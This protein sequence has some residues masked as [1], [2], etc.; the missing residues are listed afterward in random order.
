[1]NKILIA[2]LFTL[3]VGGLFA[4]DYVDDINK[5]VEMRSDGHR[6]VYEMNVGSFTTEGTF[7]AAQARLYELK[8]LGV[9][10]VWLMPI[11]PQYLLIL[12]MECHL[13]TM[14]RKL[15]EIRL[16]TISTIPRLIGLQKMIRC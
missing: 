5:S 14:V 10:V 1:M 16:S 15:A 13:F 6:V 7:S 2:L 8:T 4:A 11:Y 12:F 3:N 9:D